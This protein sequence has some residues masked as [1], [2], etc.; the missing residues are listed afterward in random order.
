V[1]SSNSCRD[2]PPAP[3]RA[4]ADSPPEHLL[5]LCYEDL[6]LDPVAQLTAVGEFLGLAEP[7]KWAGSVAHR[8]RT[9]GP[10]Q[11][12]ASRRMAGPD[13]SAG[14]CRVSG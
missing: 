14:R 2:F 8:V 3:G 13:P 12:A 5:R 1:G 11:S 9:P 10:A 6:V 4:L 7:G